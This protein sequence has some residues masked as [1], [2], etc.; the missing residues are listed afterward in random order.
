M[1]ILYYLIILC[2]L[3]YTSFAN[4]CLDESKNLFNLGNYRE[5]IKNTKNCLPDIIDSKQKAVI[6]DA[7][8]GLGINYYHIGELD[9]A[10]K[11]YQIAEKVNDFE[12]D[13]KFSSSLFNEI[14]IAYISKGLNHNALYYLRKGIEINQDID[15]FEGKSVNYAN[16]GEVFFNLNKLDSSE[17]YYNKALEFRPNSNQKNKNIILNNLGAIYFE[18]GELGNVIRALESVI[19][20]L[21]SENSMDSLLYMSNLDV[22]LIYNN[23]PPLYKDLQYKYLESS[24]YND[25]LHA[26]ANFKAAIYSLYDGKQNKAIEYLNKANAIFVSNDNITE[27]IQISNF[28]VSILNDKSYL[29]PELEQYLSELKKMKVEQYSNLLIEETY[30]RAEI[31]KSIDNLNSELEVAWTSS[32]ILLVV[33]FS[34][35]LTIPLSI[36]YVINVK[37]IT[38]L[39]AQLFSYNNQIKLIHN[40]SIKNNL[41][42]F[43]SLMVISKK[44]ENEELLTET[45]DDIVDGSNELSSFLNNINRSLNVNTTTTNELSMDRK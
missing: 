36:K 19:K 37:L 30:L 22:Y 26:D 9:S 35:V 16:L 42:K 5:S 40:N 2:L 24:G 15:N 17:Y 34:L 14:S 31:E 4:E 10:I 21:G 27:A 7:Y 12:N 13:E 28:F 18:N 3:S 41:S 44:F 43:V 45:V 6:K 8:F 23:Q 39:R 32:G 25:I 38:K 11:Y 29:L 20:N 33:L 1:K